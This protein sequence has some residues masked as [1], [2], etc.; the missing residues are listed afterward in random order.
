MLILI[1]ELAVASLLSVLLLLHNMKA[2][3]DPKNPLQV[4]ELCVIKV[5]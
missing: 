1:N 5:V 3:L 4:D 2:D